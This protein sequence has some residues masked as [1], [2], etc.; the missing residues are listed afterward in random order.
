MNVALLVTVGLGLLAL[1]VVLIAWVGPERFVRLW[2]PLP[3]KM[4]SS[5]N[6][7]I[8]AAIA[9]GGS[10]AIDYLT[11]LDIPDWLKL[12]ITAI[13]VPIVR[14]LNSADPYIDPTAITGA[15]EATD[16]TTTAEGQ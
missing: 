4:R 6:V 15:H 12:G 10:Q 3:L 9:F 11:N 8:A 1:I 7:A 5:I 16:P 2:V 14:T 13:L